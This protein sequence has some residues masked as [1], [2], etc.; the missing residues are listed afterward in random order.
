MTILGNRVPCGKTGDVVELL[1]ILGQSD[2][3]MPWILP[4]GLDTA[5]CDRTC[6]APGPFSRA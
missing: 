1:E 2:S 4:E 5:S 3:E 6:C